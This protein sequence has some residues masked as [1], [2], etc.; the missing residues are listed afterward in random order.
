MAVGKRNLYGILN[1]NFPVHSIE[2]QHAF[3]GTVTHQRVEPLISLLIDLVAKK[4]VM[5]EKASF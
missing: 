2:K 3:D 1:D 4:L 5:I